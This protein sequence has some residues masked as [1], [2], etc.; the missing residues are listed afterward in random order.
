MTMSA[1]HPQFPPTWADVFGED[2]HGIFAECWLGEVRFIWRWIFAGQFWMGCDEGNEHGFDDE[3]PQH[4]VQISQGFWMGETPVTQAQWQAVMGSNPSGFKGELR[5]VETVTWPESRSFAE[6]LNALFP[7]LGAA[8]PSEAQW[9]YACRAGTQ[10]AFNDGSACTVPEGKDPALDQLGWFDDNSGAQT[11][12]V[13]LKKPNAWGLYDMHGNVWEWCADAWD[14][15][16]SASRD[17]GAI[18]PRVD[19]TDDSADRVL[20]GGSWGGRARYCR[21]AFRAGGR[22]G[23]AWRDLGLRLAAGQ[24]EPRSGAAQVAE[25]QRAE[26]AKNKVG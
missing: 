13:K 16:A 11:H 19:N 6:K 23:S 9:E 25:P 22:P 24:N 17:A 20:R 7:G 2:D 14:E 21:A 10:T 5:P 3:K 8:L 4:L 12:E 15:K 1:L 26:R 18:D